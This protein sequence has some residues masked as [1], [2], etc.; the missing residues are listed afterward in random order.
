MSEQRAPSDAA[1]PAVHVADSEEREPLLSPDEQQ[2]EQQHASPQAQEAPTLSSNVP[3]IAKRLT[4]LLGLC[5]GGACLLLGV[6]ILYIILHIPGIVYVIRSS[7]P[8]LTS[9]SLIDTAEDSV[10]FSAKVRFPHWKRGPASVPF[11][12]ITLFHDSDM[13]GWMCAKDLEISGPATD[14]ELYQVFNIVDQ[15]AMVRLV[16]AT[17]DSRRIT[18]DTRTVVDL[19]G[20]GRF[21]PKVGVRSKVNMAVPLPPLTE[22]YTI[23]AVSGPS[24]DKERGGVTTMAAARVSIPV[25]NVSANIDAVHFDISYHDIKIATA[26]IGPINVRT[27]GIAE[28]PAAINVRE[29]SSR[30]HE[31]ALE[32][33]VRSIASGRGINL[34]VSGTSAADYST[35]PMW[36]RRALHRTSVVVSTG[37][38]SM[39]AGDL[40]SFDDMIKDIVIDRFYAYWS[41]END[42]NPWIGVSGQATVQLPNP[43]GAD[44]AVD[45]ESFVPHIQLLDDNKQVFATVDA[46]TIPFVVKQVAPLKFMAACDFD[47]IGLNVVQDREEQFTY[48]MQRALVDRH[49]VVGVNGTL[50][51]VLATSIGK[52]RIGAL[53]FYTH[54]DRKF[55][56]ECTG[57][58]CKSSSI[59]A[60]TAR[61]PSALSTSKGGPKPG[62]VPEL[63]VSRMHIA[64]TTKD[65]IVI[66][67]DIDINNPFNYGAYITDLAMNVDYKDLHV[68]KVGIK[69]LA[70][71]Q[72]AHKVTIYVD[73][74]NH[75]EDPR[76]RMLFLQ[77]SMGKNM[78]IGISGFPNCTSIAPLEASLRGFSQNI[79]ID[80]SKLKGG[81]SDKVV[82]EFPKVLR[83]IVFHLFNIAVEA[84]VVNPVSGAGIWLQSIE[85]VGYYKGDIPLGTLDYDFTVNSSR[86][87][88]AK[89]NGLLLPFNQAITT[90]RLP[91]VAND[92]TIGWD[93]LRRAIGGTLDVDVFTNVQV[94]VGNAQF[95]VTAMGKNAPVKIRL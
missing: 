90:P 48:M 66:E 92:T 43:S 25:K 44:M 30:S 3:T 70:M 86:Q 31:S 69:E 35:A 45:I 38:L 16:S 12:N 71:D 76:Q 56:S 28:V 54:V 19:S 22:N 63:I 62:R 77:A 84:T 32:D 87:G 65:L 1:S 9:A 39:P 88:S 74:Y 73:F 50:D 91:I 8:E 60:D 40:P 18:V 93:V 64:N 82:S 4:P 24:V 59:D 67:I 37:L 85:A 14:L 34:K 36:L 55:D 29:I 78:T 15:H 10:V 49:L 17:V 94:L 79:D 42:F 80:F 95:N 46:P 58:H 83:E 81:S 75:P 57:K 52:L 89:S 5:L 20:I 7:E 2:H 53:P 41:A 72:G 26:R 13:V 51:V 27:G 68:A 6:Y 33:I 21:L 61:T 11:L 23:H 47:R